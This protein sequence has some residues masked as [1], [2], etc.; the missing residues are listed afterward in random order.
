MS[1]RLILTAVLA[2]TAAAAAS[3]TPAR[4]AP[5]TPRACFHTHDWNGWRATEDAKAI[6][7]RV[8]VNQIYRLDL[9]SACANLRNP[10]AHLVISPRPTDQICNP[11][12]LDLRV[13][14]GP[15]A[16]FATPCIVSAMT[17][18]TAAEAAALPKILRP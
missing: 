15:G 14:P 12:D 9:A 13:A 11:V 3:F 16:G 8:G 7:L 18:L 2:V 4:S 17:G 1:V 10:G 6:Y 5:S